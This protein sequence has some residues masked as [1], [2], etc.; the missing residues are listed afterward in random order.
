MMYRLGLFLLAL[1]LLVVG[2]NSPT[3]SQPPIIPTTQSSLS[4]TGTVATSTQIVAAITGRRVYV[5]AVSHVPVATSVVTYTSG[6]GTNCGTGTAN[7]TGAMTFA[8]GQTIHLGSGNGALWVLPISAALCI[9]IAT[10][11]APG[12]LAFAQF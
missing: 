4:I 10:A 2:V 11:V 12:S 6:T 5:T 9:T 1:G 8:A 7:V 3:T